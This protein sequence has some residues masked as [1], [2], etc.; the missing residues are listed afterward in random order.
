MMD[1]ISECPLN[2]IILHS[3][4]ITFSLNIMDQSKFYHLTVQQGIIWRSP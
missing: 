2:V 1:T 4:L 3:I